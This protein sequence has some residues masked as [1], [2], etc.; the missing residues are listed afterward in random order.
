MIVASQSLN[1]TA[2]AIVVA[3]VA[4]MIIAAVMTTMMKLNVHVGSPMMS[5]LT[6]VKEFDSHKLLPP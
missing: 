1:L 2:T 4:A 5:S 3:V 6:D